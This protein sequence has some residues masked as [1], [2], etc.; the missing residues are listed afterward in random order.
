MPGDAEVP[1]IGKIVKDDGTAV[2]NA[3]MKTVSEDYIDVAAVT[4]LLQA[5]QLLGD[6]I[7]MIIRPTGYQ[8]DYTFMTQGERALDNVTKATAL[9]AINNYLNM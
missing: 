3:A 4:L 7:R 5:G 8:P 2:Y 6:G 1:G 9:V